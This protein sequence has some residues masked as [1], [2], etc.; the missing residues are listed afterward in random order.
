M[1]FI[2]MLLGSLALVMVSTPSVAQQPSIYLY[3]V[4]LWC[5][6]SNGYRVPIYDDPQSAAIARSY[7]GGVATRDA[8][9]SRIA[10][11]PATMNS[12]PRLSAFMIFFHECGHVALPFGIGVGSP[13]QEANAD[14]FAIRMMRDFGLIGNWSQFNEAVAYASGGHGMNARVSNM[15]NCISWS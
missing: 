4:E 11:D 2:S 8:Y 14:C 3:G 7:G 12:V 5:N 10:L 15:Y 13:E 6:D 9:G 1:R